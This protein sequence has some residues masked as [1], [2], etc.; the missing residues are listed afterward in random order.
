MSKQLGIALEMKQAKNQLYAGKPLR[1][2]GIIELSS[3]SCKFMM[4]DLT[5]LLS[6]FSWDAFQNE[7]ARIYI[8]Q[9]F[10][11]E[12]NLAWR[13][14]EEQV[15][16]LVLRYV[17][18]AK[19]RHVERLC[20]VATSSFRDAQNCDEILSKLEFYYGIK[21][22]VLH[23]DLEATA[24]LMALSWNAP[25]KDITQGI[26]ID[27]GG[28]STEIIVF[29]EDFQVH[30]MLNSSLG[31]Q[32]L[33]KIFLQKAVFRRKE[34]IPL[35]LEEMNKEIE[36]QFRPLNTPK[37]SSRNAID[38][39]GMGG[40]LSQLTGKTGNRKQHGFR[41]QRKELEKTQES[42]EQSIVQ[43]FSSSSI[44]SYVKKHRT[45]SEPC[46][47][48]L[49]LYFGIEMLLFL[50]RLV[51]QEQILV[52]GLGLRYGIFYQQILKEY[53]D[54]FQAPSSYANLF[55]R[56]KPS[57]HGLHEGDLVLGTIKRVH[58]RLG[59]FVQLKK[60][61]DG[62]ISRQNLKKQRVNLD[63]YQ[64][65]A[66]VQVQITMILFGESPRFVLTL[67]AD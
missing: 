47:E 59:I 31:T 40:V 11:A 16:P 22:Q 21:V 61:V 51:Q 26:L 29:D 50:L 38:L 36:A 23:Q 32:S 5:Q 60:G 9:H 48:E 56:T 35:V 27:Q 55:Q 20:C 34:E 30:S 8:H 4:G 37:I 25:R 24:S 57:V 1:R 10:D 33:A 65:N 19:K 46:F 3:T 18:L 17:E 6:G 12:G 14:F 49:R 41:L 64:E 44:R 13:Y 67:I 66:L 42:V 7:S 43:Q 15:V 45:V 63:Q 62:L 54:F 58:H 39:I 52:Q 53:P 2:L 28:G